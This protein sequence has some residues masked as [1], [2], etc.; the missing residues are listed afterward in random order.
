[1]QYVGG[2]SA[3]AR[4]TVYAIERYRHSRSIW[5]EPFV[6]GGAVLNVA[7]KY[8]PSCYAYDL[9]PDL[10]LMYQA[11]QHNWQPP[12]QV[13]EDEYQ[14]LRHAKPSAL[15]GF[16]GFGCSFG[17]KWFGG[18]AR[19]AR[20]GRNYAAAARKSLLQMNLKNT[21][22]V[23]QSFFAINWSQFNP[24]DCVVYCDLPYSNTQG[25]SVGGFDHAAFWLQCEQL[26]DLGFLVVV[27]EYSAPESWSC[28]WRKES[29]LQLSG[30]AISNARIERLF[31]PSLISTPY[32]ME[33]SQ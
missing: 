16:V 8:Y 17:G 11:L 22:F 2:K 20:K 10:I 32:Y 26:H 7:T 30:G 21:T 33:L 29:K 3:I 1:M 18:Y 28:L 5:I 12:A 13:D 25:Y 23:Q 24:H 4:D 27:S 14:A 9:H 6:G 15:R 19:S 31:T